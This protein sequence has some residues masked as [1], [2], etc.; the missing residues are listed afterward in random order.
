M[1]FLV[2]IP[3]MLDPKLPRGFVAFHEVWIS[4]SQEMPIP[5]FSEFASFHDFQS[6]DSRSH[7]ASL[8]QC[9][10]GASIFVCLWVNICVV[11][12]FEMLECFCLQTMRVTLSVLKPPHPSQAPHWEWRQQLLSPLLPLPSPKLGSGGLGMT[13]RMSLLEWFLSKWGN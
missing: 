3:A 13:P 12:L 11:F 10:K 6:A 9:L 2:E 7:W 1:K 4:S 8:C 5:E